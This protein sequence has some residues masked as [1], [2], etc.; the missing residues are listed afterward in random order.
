[1]LNH[2]VP[3]DELTLRMFGQDAWEKRRK[4]ATAVDVINRKYGRGTIHVG[5]AP[6]LG[7]W[8]TMAERRSPRYTTDWRELCPV[9]A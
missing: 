8:Q 2:L 9:R 4:V 6:A 5:E 7:K 3:S 1:M